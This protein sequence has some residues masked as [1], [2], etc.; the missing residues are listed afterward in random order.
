MMVDKLIIADNDVAFVESL[1]EYY[2]VR[3]VEVKT[4]YDAITVLKL[5]HLSEPDA[6]CLGVNMQCANGVS[7]CEML[8][9]ERR[10]S[11]LPIVLLTDRADDWLAHDC[12]DL[13][14]YYVAKGP[15]LARRTE[16]LLDEVSSHAPLVVAE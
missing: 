14:A 12:H 4:A 1:A 8:A 3:G 2:R 11:Y 13:Q 10:F 6:M 9:A 7:V 15:E 5:V 16:L